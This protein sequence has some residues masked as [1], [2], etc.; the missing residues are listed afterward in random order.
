MI[1]LVSTDQLLLL[2]HLAFYKK[3]RNPQTFCITWYA[4]KFYIHLH[5][6]SP[7][8]R[9]M[10]GL[11]NE[12]LGIKMC[13]GPLMNR[14]LWSIITIA[15][16][17][18]G[19]PI[20]AGADARGTMRYLAPLGIWNCFLFS[21]FPLPEPSCV[22]FCGCAVVFQL[23]RSYSIYQHVRNCSASEGSS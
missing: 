19:L 12:G 1:I 23:S 3:T 15:R 14:I 6:S 10:H 4:G 21:A 20:S 8:S 5:P 17:N 11:Q 13:A 7:D 16:L 22:C 18:I 9:C 2:C